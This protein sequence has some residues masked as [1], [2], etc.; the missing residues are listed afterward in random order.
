MSDYD[1]YGPE[2]APTCAHWCDLGGDCTECAMENETVRDTLA[3]KDRMI[4]RL[5]TLYVGY[6]QM[7]RDGSAHTF[8]EFVNDALSGAERVAVGRIVERFALSSAAG[9]DWWWYSD[10]SKALIEP[11]ERLKRRDTVEHEAAAKERARNVAALRKRAD[12]L[13]SAYGEKEEN[14]VNEL[15][16][17][18]DAIERGDR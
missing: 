1:D 13:W 11:G 18:A 14:A 17:Q 2:S 16:D 12:Y 8:F 5:F 4:R 6:R 10:W 7:W 3:R 15:R 9:S